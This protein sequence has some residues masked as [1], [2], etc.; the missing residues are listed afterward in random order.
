MMALLKLAAGELR[1]KISAKTLMWKNIF[2]T[3]IKKDDWAFVN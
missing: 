3:R 2:I 1:L